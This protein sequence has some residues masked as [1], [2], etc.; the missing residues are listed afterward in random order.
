MSQQLNTDVG[1][2][3]GLELCEE[4]SSLPFPPRLRY[5]LKL[6]ASDSSVPL[7]YAVQSGEE[8]KGGSTQ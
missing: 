7:R 2:M 6:W 4:E 8:I 5:E 1:V 3:E